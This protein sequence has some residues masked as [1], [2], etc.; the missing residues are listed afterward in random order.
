MAQNKLWYYT[1]VA[2]RAFVKALVWSF[3]G[4]FAVGIFT[5]V[6][7]IITAYIKLIW[8]ACAIYFN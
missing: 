4:F 5:V 7:C 2:R 3:C 1:T 8:N 6:A